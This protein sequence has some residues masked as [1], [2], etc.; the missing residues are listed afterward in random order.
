MTFLHDFHPGV[1]RTGEWLQRMVAC[2]A[3]FGADTLILMGACLFMKQ[4]ESCTGAGVLQ[5]VVNDADADAAL[6]RRARLV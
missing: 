4:Q 5:E 2:W 1:T 3:D 6:R